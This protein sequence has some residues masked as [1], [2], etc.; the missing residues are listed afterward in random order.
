MTS[1]VLAHSEDYKRRLRLD[2]LPYATPLDLTEEPLPPG[3]PDIVLRPSAWDR[4]IWWVAPSG[5]GRS[6]TGNWLV[7]R[8]LAG[9]V[10]RPTFDEAV[11]A[12]PEDRACFVE[13]WS[14]SAE[15][16]VKPPGG[17]LCVAAPFY[18]DERVADSWR[19][20]QSPKVAD[21]AAALVQ[22]AALRLP[23]DGHFVPA[24]AEEW[25]EAAAVRGEVDGLGAA[26]GFLGLIDQYGAP[27][28]ARRGVAKMANRFVRDRL[29]ELRRTGA[30]DAAWLTEAAPDVLSDL[31]KRMLTS[32]D[33]SWEEPRPFDEWAELI[34]GEHQGP[35][36]AEWIRASLGRAKSPPTVK[37]LDHALKDLSPGP[38]RIVRAFEQAGLLR[39]K[40]GS[41]LLALGP[42]WL[43]RHLA[44]AAKTRIADG[45]PAEWSE[46]L[47]A[48]HAAAPTA[49]A[50][51]ARVL[52]GDLSLLEDALEQADEHD[53]VTVA[54]L[55]AAFRAAGLA[56]L[57]GIEVPEDVA[58]ALW[59]QQMALVVEL[60]D[61][62]H[63]RLGYGSFA[64]G[65]P[66]LAVGTFRL[67]A[68]ALS[69]TLPP[70]RGMPHP[71]LRPFTAT[72]PS[73][74]MS[75]LDSIWSVVRKLDAQAMAWARG[76]YGLSTRVRSALAENARGAGAPASRRAATSE[77]PPHP[78]EWPDR[79]LSAIGRGELRFRDVGSAPPELVSALFAL[80]AHQGTD[81][82]TVAVAFWTAWAREPGPLHDDAPLSPSGPHWR[83]FY[84]SAPA[85]ALEVLFGRGF[86]SR[87]HVPYALF[88][89][90][91]WRGV[92]ASRADAVSGVPAAWAAMP[93]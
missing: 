50:L 68:I 42:R 34:P 23:R 16:A 53:P 71:V 55:E 32:P 64:D 57:S 44:E 4:P 61:G 41:D 13:L 5:S 11:G 66:L 24:L 72:E 20:V 63:P 80:A 78:L 15:R 38:F 46:A 62:P 85:A 14:D 18:P 70:Q 79:V 47:L 49:R 6:L 40:H 58:L 45:I 75:A 92:L 73:L 69:E 30:L 29:A 83:R 28:L 7:A 87:E 31:M 36:D 48:P 35:L 12:L 93:P 54:A 17:P 90:A 19:I 22:W 25:L 9:F 91:A 59:E 82:R 65:E 21:F 76:A 51:F 84:S 86:V 26:L 33:R 74:G 37:E 8:R 10:M 67:A 39:S 2:D 27:E 52:N 89:E 3:I 60:E 81:P 43:A 88:D 56:T 1:A 77:P